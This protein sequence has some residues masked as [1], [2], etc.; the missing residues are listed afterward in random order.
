M[1]RVM[2]DFFATKDFT[3]L[4]KVKSAHLLL[5]L[6]DTGGDFFTVKHSNLPPPFG[7]VFQFCRFFFMPHLLNPPKTLKPPSSTI[8]GDQ[9]SRRV[10]RSGSEAVR[11]AEDMVVAMET[12]LQ[13]TWHGERWTG[14]KD[15]DSSLSKQCAC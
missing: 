7:P 11:Q 2:L 3:I 14:W 15:R 8:S 12:E 4:R 5:E 9:S 10:G 6:L 1:N 13:A